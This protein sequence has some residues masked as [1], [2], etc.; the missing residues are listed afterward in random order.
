MF[1]ESRHDTLWFPVAE[2]RHITGDMVSFNTIA[3]I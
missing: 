3:I 1:Y 2:K